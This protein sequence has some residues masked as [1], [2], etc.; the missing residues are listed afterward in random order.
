MSRMPKGHRLGDV[1]VEQGALGRSTLE[2][3]CADEPTRPLGRLL[4]EKRLIQKE[5]LT[6]ALRAQIQWLFNRLF[7]EEA[8]NFTFWIGPPIN[9]EDGVRL[10]TTSLLLEGA[11]SSDEADGNLHTVGEDAAAKLEES[12]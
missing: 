1:L 7:R 5:H 4:L 3:A 2:D 9:S 11:R 12:S 8:K 6:E 10:N